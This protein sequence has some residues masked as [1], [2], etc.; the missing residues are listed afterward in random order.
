MSPSVPSLVI[1]REGTTIE[2]DHCLLGGIRAVDN[3]EVSMTNTLVDAASPT[4][5]AYAT[6]DGQA[7]GGAEHRELHGDR[8]GACKRWISRR[9]PSSRP[10]SPGD[11]WSHPVW[12]EQ[13][14]A[15]LLP[16]SF[17]PLNSVSPPVPLPTGF[18]RGGGPVETDQPKGSLTGP[19]TEA[20]TLATQARVRLAFTRSPLRAG[21]LWAIGGRCPENPSWGRR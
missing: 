6:L 13:N 5:V 20:I 15:R 1:E 11:N 21:R 19:Q 4:G 17:V 7:S 9:I 16:V 14:P 12:S 10:P 3:T 18:G 8:Q 2:I